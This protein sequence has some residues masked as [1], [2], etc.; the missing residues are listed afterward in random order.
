MRK[1]FK[2]ICGLQI[3]PYICSPVSRECIAEIAQLV[4]RNLAKVKVAGPSPVFRSTLRNLSFGRFFVCFWLLP[5]FTV[6]SSSV[7]RALLRVMP[8]PCHARLCVMPDSI[9]YL[10]LRPTSRASRA[11]SQATEAARYRACGRRVTRAH[12]SAGRAG[13]F[14]KGKS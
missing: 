11:A 2:K 12:Q 9:G 7:C 10:P 1:L 14:P 4:E 8:P 13:T 5:P 3:L 6:V